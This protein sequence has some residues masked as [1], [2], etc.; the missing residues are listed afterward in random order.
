MRTYVQGA[1]EVIESEDKRA[2][3]T[4]HTVPTEDVDPKVV[5]GYARL[6]AEFVAEIEK[7]EAHAPKWRAAKTSASALRLPKSADAPGF[8][9]DLFAVGDWVEWFEGDTRIVGQVWSHAPRAGSFWITTDR[10]GVSGRAHV[11]NRSKVPGSGTGKAARY[12]YRVGGSTVRS[13]GAAG[14]DVDMSGLPDSLGIRSEA[15]ESYAD[16]APRKGY[17][18]YAPVPVHV[19]AVEVRGDRVWFPMVIDG[20]RMDA[21]ARGGGEWL[22]SVP[23]AGRESLAV[24]SAPVVKGM[25]TLRAI[26]M[27]RELR[28]RANGVRYGGN[29]KYVVRE[30]EAF[31][32]DCH[33]CQEPRERT[34]GN[35]RMFTYE[36]GLTRTMC[37]THIARALSYRTHDGRHHEVT[38]AA[39]EA[40]GDAQKIMSMRDS[41]AARAMVAV[42]TGEIDA[43]EVAESAAEETRA[44]Q[45]AETCAKAAEAAADRAERAAE[46]AAESKGTTDADGAWSD[47][48]AAERAARDVEVRA[49]QIPAEREAYADRARD[50]VNRAQDAAERAR[51]AADDRQGA[52]DDERCGMAAADDA[53]V[54]AEAAR[55]AAAATER[56]AMSC[57]RVRDFPALLAGWVRDARAEAAEATQAAERARAAVTSREAEQRPWGRIEWFTVA[58]SCAD[59]ARDAA[60][61]AQQSA[62]LAAQAR[63]RADRMAAEV[64]PD[65][66]AEESAPVVAGPVRAAQQRAEE[67]ERAAEEARLRA[68]RLQE[69][70]SGHYGR[71]AGGQPI[72]MGHHSARGALR[73]RAKGD[74]ATRRAIEAADAAKR[75]EG[76]ARGARQ[77]AE[78]AATVHG[79]SRPWERGDFQPGDV[80]EVRKRYTATY[81]VVRANAKTLTLRN[82]NTI[83]DLKARYDQVIS[84]T[85]DGQTVTDPEHVDTLP[86][87]PAAAAVEEPRE[88]AAQWVPVP[89]GE[90]WDFARVRQ[91]LARRDLAEGDL[92][93]C[94]GWQV[95]P[96]MW[97]VMITRVQ[98]GS[99][100]RPRG[101]A[102]EKWDAAFRA[103]GE[104]VEAAG[105]A[106]VRR[107][108]HCVVVRVPVPAELQPIARARR[109][110]SLDSSTTSVA[111][112]GFDTIGETVQ[113]R[114][115]GAGAATYEVRD[116]TGRG[117]DA[118]QNDRQSATASL[119]HWYGLPTPAEYIEDSR[120]QNP[121][122]A[123]APAE[124]YWE[125][126]P[127]G[128]RPAPGPG[129]G[130]ERKRCSSPKGEEVSAATSR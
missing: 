101:K 74:A 63:G 125:R 28:E 94:N 21:D 108:A 120:T 88:P 38:T 84:R 106:V 114:S 53:E 56:W 103:Y 96:D 71:F 39:V 57:P 121:A 115:A 43:P 124:A 27:L 130:R 49:A 81:W 60:K 50:A 73:D 111:F 110:G 86:P 25:V 122:E 51:C 46:A 17:Q 65:V 117:I 4:L 116:H 31:A 128:S 6:K 14:T 3:F 59:D 91:V 68:E 54:A 123:A 41:L 66:P 69:A 79:R 97:D 30:V 52:A 20:V 10:S 75:A 32:R 26:G 12:T 87:V 29:R 8:V 42:I 47:A 58:G 24:A 72:L 22:V 107:N 119:A 48:E 78:L 90:R 126:A 55:D 77:A 76:V 23:G 36:K 62:K 80:V 33:K 89:D 15:P 1:F 64:A 44:D 83:D 9:A 82:A 37:A 113:L 98:A 7:R 18:P 35:G 109:I 104:A 118:A 13:M 129:R 34:T 93:V 11:M 2:R 70:A 127:P 67:A 100:F 5:Q 112:D 45:S 95:G 16:H 99:P 61:R 92:G 19:G 105:M 102:R 40:I 85:R